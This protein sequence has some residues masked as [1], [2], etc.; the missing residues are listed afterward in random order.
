MVNWFSFFEEE[1]KKA[2]GEKSLLLH[3]CC[4]P[5]SSSVLKTL[6]AAFKIT[7]FYSNSNIFPFE[8]FEKREAEQQRLCSLWKYPVITDAYNH[9]D[10]LKSV[11]GLEK[12]Q[13]GGERCRACIAYRMEQT[14]RLAKEKGFDY[15]TTTLSVSPHKNANYINETGKALE[16][17]YGVKYLYADFKKKDGYLNSIRLSKELELYRQSYC[18]CEFSIR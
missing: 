11:T 12:E 16:E 8:E 2:N 14:A 9:S 6:E 5:C 7:V 1:F 3:S 10:F 18:G 15:F 17:K 13:E 4:A